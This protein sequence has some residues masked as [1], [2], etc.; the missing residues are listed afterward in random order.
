MIAEQLGVEKDKVTR[1]AQRGRCFR[2]HGSNG[3][4]QG[5]VFVEEKLRWLEKAKKQMPKQRS[6]AILDRPINTVKARPNGLEGL[7]RSKGPEAS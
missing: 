7:G 2:R 5:I 3:W 1:E 6:F 4:V